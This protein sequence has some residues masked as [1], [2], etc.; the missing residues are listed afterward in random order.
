MRVS[1]RLLNSKKMA[2]VTRGQGIGAIVLGILKLLVGLIIV[3]IGFVLKSKVDNA[4]VACF[5]AGFVVK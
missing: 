1:D 4:I 3:I 5:W 2:Y